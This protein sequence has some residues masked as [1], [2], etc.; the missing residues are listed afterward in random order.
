MFRQLAGPT[1][2]GADRLFR[3][4]PL[5]L[6]ALLEQ[7]WKLGIRGCPDHAHPLNRGIL[8]GMPDRW[9]ASAKLGPNPEPPVAG[10]REA[11]PVLW[12]HLI[13]AFMIENTGIYEVFRKVLHAYL[14]GEEL[15]FPLEDAVPWLRSTE[16]LFYQNGPPFFIH[17]LTSTIRPSLCSS[18]RGAYYRMFGIELSHPGESD[19][20][21]EKAKEAN[22]QFGFTFE[23]FLREVWVG[24]NEV[25]GSEDRQTSDRKIAS[26]ARKLRGMLS[27]RRSGGNLAREEFFF[28]SMMSWFHL[29]LEYDSPIV[30]TLGAQAA[31]PGRR[32]QRIA[33]K[34]GVPAHALAADFF[35]IADAISRILLQI[36]TGTYDHAEAAPALYIPVQGGGPEQDIRTIITH[37]SITHLHAL[38]FDKVP[39]N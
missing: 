1:E 6:N 37:W 33:E 8:E 10:K 5:E 12:D 38:K 18:R 28:V 20:S 4:H 3:Q 31:S 7:S 29:T 19:R 22:T 17:S 27:M 14:H 21:F 11:K 2:K 30:R 26:L 34:V 16:A 15:G 9:L 25:Q 24:M 32:L 36:E 13:Y 35:D 39:A 23:E